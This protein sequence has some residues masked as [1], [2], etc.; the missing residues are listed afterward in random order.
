MYYYFFQTSLETLPNGNM[1]PR[2]RPLPGQVFPD[3]TPVDETLNVQSPKEKDTSPYGS[4]FDYPE[5]TFFCSDHLELNT[6]KNIPY[7]TVYD[8]SKGEEFGKTWPNFHPVSDDPSFSYV[9]PQHESPVMN[10]AFVLFK[11]YNT[12]EVEDSEG[13]TENTQDTTPK[14]RISPADENGIARQKIEGWAERYEG[15]LETE[16]DLFASWI[17]KLMAENRVNLGIR[18][19][20]SKYSGTFKNLYAMGETIDTLA[21][22]TRFEKLMA[23]NKMSWEDFK[24]QPNG[25]HGWYLISL[26]NEHVN[27]QTCTAVQRDPNNAKEVDDASQIVCSVHNAQSSHSCAHTGTA[28]S[29]VKK[30]LQAGWTVDDMIESE[31]IAKADTF[32]EYAKAL[33]NGTIPVPVSN[34]ITGKCS[35]I[36]ALLADSKY[37]KPKDKEGFH[38]EDKTWRILVHNLHQKEATCLAGP[39]GTGKTEII[40]LLCDKAGVPWTIIPMGTITDPVEQLIGKPILEGGNETYDWAEF[41]LAIQKPGVIILDELNRTPKNGENVLFSVLDNTREL[42]ASGSFGNVEK[43]IKVHPDC[44]FFATANCA[45]GGKKDN[46]YNATKG[47]DAA[48]ASRFMFVEMDYMDM[49][50]EA[51]TMIARFGINKDDAKAISAVVRTIR[52]TSKNNDFNVDVSTRDSHRCAS[53]VKDGFSCKEA[54]EYIF[55]PKFDAGSGSRILGSPLDPNSERAVIAKAVESLFNNKKTA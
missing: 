21:S 15:Q 22:R 7:Y 6:E 40:K 32:P 51:E 1:R 16:S 11:V 46:N 27:G 2:L 49:K 39:T 30:A 48:I 25:P 31:N 55:Y 35:L 50:A 45:A 23:D 52:E 47:I 43:R 41:A 29:D 36:D 54:V 20:M 38:V 4:R 8:A 17:K 53:L 34:T 18:I 37:A 44:V 3:G 10:S 9:K 33:A 28:L 19:L 12:Q 42:V 13:N 26:Y 14:M 5:G 24:L